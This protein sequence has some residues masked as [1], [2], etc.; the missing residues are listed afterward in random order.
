VLVS[1]LTCQDIPE[2][3][4][5]KMTDTIGR[6][7]FLMKFPVVQKPFYVSRPEDDDSVTESVDLLMPGV[8]EI[9]GGSMREWNEE[10]LLAGYK[11]QGLENIK[12]YYWYNELVGCRLPFI[13]EVLLENFWNVSSWRIWIGYGAIS[14]LAP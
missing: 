1:F 12:P 10:K 4:E 5:R 11:R 2:A 3:P 13:S 8:G 7:I 6:P 9:V 14:L